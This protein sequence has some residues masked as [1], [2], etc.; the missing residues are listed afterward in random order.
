M[1]A[2]WHIQTHISHV[3]AGGAS[4]YYTVVAPLEAD[5]LEQYRRMK[6]AASEAI[7]TVGA[8]ISHHHAVGIDHAP[9]LAAE[10]GELGMAMLAAVKRCV[11][12]VGVLNPDKLITMKAGMDD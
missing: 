6:A 1:G 2:R 12:P 5:G 4:L 7:V 3:Y 8:T 10:V 11:D 9:Y